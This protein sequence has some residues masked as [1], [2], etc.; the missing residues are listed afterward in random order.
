MRWDGI[1][2]ANIVK[3]ELYNFCV[4]A[5]SEVFGRS[6][7]EYSELLKKRY[8]HSGGTGITNG[9]YINAKSDGIELHFKTPREELGNERNILLPWSMA[10]RHIRA[11]EFEKRYQEDVPAEKPSVHQQWEQT[12]LCGD[13]YGEHCEFLL[14][15]NNDTI[16]NGKKLDSWCPYCT[17]ENKVRK[18]G[19]AGMWTGLSPKFCPKRKEIV[20]GQNGNEEDNT[21]ARKL[22]FDTAITKDMQSAA[23]DSFMDNI[24][25]IDIKDIKPSGDNFYEISDIDLLADDIEREGLKHN[26]VVAKAPDGC[27]YY[28][29]SGHRRLAAIK[30]LVEQKRRSSTKIPC[31]VDGSKTQAES[32]LDLIMLNATQRKYTDAD[33]MHEYEELERTF[34]ALEAE[35]KP[36]KGRMRENIAAALKVSPA[37]VGKIE[38]I[39]HNAIPEVEKAVKSGEMSIS[40]ANEVAKLPEKKQQEIVKEQPK[41]SHKDVKEIQQQ[42]KPKSP[43]FQKNEI[44]VDDE[45]PFEGDFGDCIEDVESEADEKAAQEI[46]AEK[47]APVADKS[48]NADRTF[49]LTFKEAEAL[50][51]FLDD[52]AEGEDEVAGIWDK[53]KNF[54]DKS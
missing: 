30:L 43:V 42:E 27:G 41:I 19:S 13:F 37:Q 6:N 31:Y 48:V 14:Q 46:K 47:N 17:S 21:M 10:A 35:G 45:E 51:N 26:I 28:V 22:Q 8:N 5:I 1:T 32:Q 24:K 16:I 52:W 4:Y 3:A 34:K 12:H 38:N 29:K 7:A 39:K 9:V 54:F 11:W 15:A 36:L 25:M 33:I 23:S 44:K 50:L 40:T 49:T 2:L 18:I 53:L 20:H